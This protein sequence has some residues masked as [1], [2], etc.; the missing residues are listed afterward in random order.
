MNVQEGAD[1]GGDDGARATFCLYTLSGDI[2]SDCIQQGHLKEGSLPDRSSPHKFDC[3]LYFIQFRVW[4]W[5]KCLWPK[6]DSHL[7][8]LNGFTS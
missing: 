6:V 4:R 2:L 7:A 1:H 8:H 5:S 3:N